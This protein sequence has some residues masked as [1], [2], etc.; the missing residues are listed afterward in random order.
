MSFF[1][2]RFFNKNQ[3]GR[4]FVVGDIHGM[5]SLLESQLESLDFNPDVDRVFS[6]GDLIDRGPE[7]YRVLEFLDKPW[8]HAIKG[9]HEMMLIEAKHKKTHYRSWIKNNGGEWWEDIDP[10]TQT[11]I[12]ERLTDLPVA[13][14]VASNSGRVGIVHAD[15]PV[16]QSWQEIVHSVYFDEE[17]RNY[18]MWSRNRYKYIELTGETS[19][20]EGIDLVVMGHTPIEKPLAI[21]NLYYIDTG[22]AYLQKENLGYLTM[23]QIHPKIEVF[24]YPQHLIDT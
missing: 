23:L 16:G 19:F 20:V 10:A 22:A 9:N 5:F 14:E 21:S 3:F 4:D 11:E 24:Q 2:F 1:P 6:V 8:F 15:V 17:V 13:F 18:M 12:R 7:S